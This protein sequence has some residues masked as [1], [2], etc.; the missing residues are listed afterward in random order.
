MA[1]EIAR[2]EQYGT[3]ADV[4][5]FSILLWELATLQIPFRKYR[6]LESLEIRVVDG[7]ERPSTRSIPNKNLQNLLKCCWSDSPEKRPPVALVR[8]KLEEIVEELTKQQPRRTFMIK[9][10][11]TFK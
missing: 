6:T 7:Q 4:Y 3:A 1:P 10:L 5:S 2:C 11:L 9:E 8:I